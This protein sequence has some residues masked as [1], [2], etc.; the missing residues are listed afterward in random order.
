MAL[1]NPYTINNTFVITVDYI[2]VF[3]IVNTNINTMVMTGVMAVV[4]AC[5]NHKIKNKILIFIIAM[6]RMLILFKYDYGREK[7][8]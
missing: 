2:N 5:V 7:Y 6:F 1:A 3:T 8:A 4:L